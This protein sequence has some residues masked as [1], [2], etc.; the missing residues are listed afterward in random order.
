MKKV[1]LIIFGV[2]AILSFSSVVLINR[3]VTQT[4]ENSAQELIEDY[5]SAGDLEIRYADLWFNVIRSQVTVQNLTYIQ[6][7]DTIQSESTT[8]HIRLSDLISSLS[9]ETEMSVTNA[10]V[11]FQN[12]SLD[13][14][15]EW[16]FLTQ[17]EIVISAKIDYQTQEVLVSKIGFNLKE[18]KIAN[19][20]AEANANSL[21]FVMDLGEKETNLQ[22]LA[23]EPNESIL[24]L[25]R[26]L[27]TFE[28]QDIAFTLGETSLP[29]ALDFDFL[30]ADR[31]R[32]DAQKNEEY[33]DLDCQMETT[34]GA[35]DMNC[36]VDLSTINDDPVIET[37]ID[38]SGLSE[39]LR[40]LLQT[41]IGWD[42]EKDNY[43]FEYQ[44]KVSE[45]EMALI[46]SLM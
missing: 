41:Q 12:L 30:Q 46:V 3:Y 19:A 14:Q 21:D 40:G 27:L 42:P 31:I 37:S 2:A 44:G 6:D 34:N 35:I 33:F 9:N 25:D 1:L 13:T 11:G 36:S 20:D 32:F 5:T 18:F 16:M 45:I 24:A 15:L 29:Q 4:I 43:T 10:T 39:E 22:T 38:V 23:T 28:I 26:I 17:G 8:L 7:G